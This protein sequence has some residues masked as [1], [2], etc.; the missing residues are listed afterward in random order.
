MLKG[1]VERINN[2]VPSAKAQIIDPPEEVGD[3]V[4]LIEADSLLDVAKHLRHNK[5]YQ[6]PVLQVISGV[7]YLEYMEVCYFVAN[8]DLVKPFDFM[9]KVRV[10]DRIAPELDSV[11]EIWK[12]ANWQERECYDMIGVT[13]RN[14]PDHR[15]I[16][17]PDDWEGFP[18]RKDYVTAKTYRD[19][20]TFPDDKMNL[21][22]RCFIVHQKKKPEEVRDE[23]LAKGH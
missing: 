13:F 19:M 3:S 16:L 6:F 14:H 10:K 5:T 11:C 21:E 15:R 18:L 7:D 2:E 23:F 1:I 17:C 8:F 4:V 20:E 12:A 22:D 9:F